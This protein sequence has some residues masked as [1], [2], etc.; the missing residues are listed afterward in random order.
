MIRQQIHHTIEGGHYHDTCVYIGERLYSEQRPRV[1]LWSPDRRDQFR[2]L[3][4]WPGLPDMVVTKT[5]KH[6]IK[7][8]YV[9]EF[10][11]NG[12]DKKIF[13]KTR[14]FKRY[15]I[16]DVIV[17]PINPFINQHNWEEL[18]RQIEEWLP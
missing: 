16:T 9:I 17:I 5:E 13:V 2:F 7:R 1:E 3:E 10:E 8:T 18:E 12:N 14:Q 11:N 15:G 6:Q 4:E